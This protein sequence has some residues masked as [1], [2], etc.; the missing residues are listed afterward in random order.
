M[1]ACCALTL[2]WAFTLLPIPE[3]GRPLARACDDPAPRPVASALEVM[4]A[5]YAI[6]DRP[7]GRAPSRLGH[8]AYGPRTLA[9]RPSFAQG[10]NGPIAGPS[11]RPGDPAGLGRNPV[12]RC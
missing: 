10:T 11:P 9:T 6:L 12:L 7:P 8:R 2:T 5:G 4:P 3:S 1:S